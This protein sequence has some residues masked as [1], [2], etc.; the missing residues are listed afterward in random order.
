MNGKYICVDARMLGNSGIGV[1][2]EKIIIGLAQSDNFKLLLLVRPE[3]KGYFNH[4]LGSNLDYKVVKSSIYS[5]FE[6]F[7]LSISIPRCDVYWSP[8]FNS[9]F[10][11]TLA[12]SRICTIHDVFH[13]A[14]TQYYSTPKNIYIRFRYWI[15]CLLSKRII[16]VSK[17][18]KEELVKYF[19]HINE[20]NITVVHNGLKFDGQANQERLVKNDILKIL[21]VGN[22]KPHKN[23]K[24]LLSAFKKIDIPKQLTIV[25]QTNGF[26][27]PIEEKVLREA[28][29][30]KD[31]Q[32]M[33]KVDETQLINCYKNAD[34]LVFP[35]LYEGFGLPILEA[36]HYGLPSIISDIRPFREVAGNAALYFNPYSSNDLADKIKYLYYNEEHQM[37]MVSNGK[38]RLADFSWDKS[39]HAHIQ[40][41]EECCN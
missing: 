32:I 33:G 2:L 29:K 37:N 41:F 18:T 4:S 25:G 10:F 12:K 19:W 28:K 35:S 27:K 31:I 22:L 38:E 11:P 7:E 15:T 13:L 9:S 21:F 26:L 20:K 17:F 24:C 16:V 5:P 6:S 34:V 40:L 3:H 8:H 36:F 14:N 39:T 30:A 1:Y 23:L